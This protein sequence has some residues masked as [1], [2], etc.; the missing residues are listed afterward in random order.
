MVV[1]SAT[2]TYNIPYFDK[3]SKLFVPKF[4]NFIF[5]LEINM[6]ILI[7]LKQHTYHNLLF[8]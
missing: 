6:E 7:N 2:D 3:F 5:H 1:S 4:L 8:Q